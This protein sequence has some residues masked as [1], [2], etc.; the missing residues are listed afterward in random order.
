VFDFALTLTLVVVRLITYISYMSNLPYVVRYVTVGVAVEV[1][2]VG[3]CI[4][5]YQWLTVTVALD[6]FRAISKEI[7]DV[8]R[9]LKIQFT[10]FNIVSTVGSTIFW[11]VAGSYRAKG[12]RENTNLWVAISFGWFGIATVLGWTI[13]LF[14]L[15]R[16]LKHL[17][18][19]LLDAETSVVVQRVIGK[20]LF[21][22]PNKTKTKTTH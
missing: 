3:M 2:K 7:G 9:N 22:L 4:I 5:L 14:V 11:T 1:L 20:V 17:T 16:R 10:T 6:N 8:I 19:I 21:P 15:S 18:T 13:I 12:D